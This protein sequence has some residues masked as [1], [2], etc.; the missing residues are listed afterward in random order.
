MV[1]LLRNVSDFIA[2]RKGLPVLIG[3]G[4]V[5]LNL[6]I[7]LLPAWPVITWFARTDIFLQ[8]G[9]IVG[10]MGILIGDAL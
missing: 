7:S 9:V 4:L 5:L 10:L 2:H 3:V 6:V 1:E 8:L